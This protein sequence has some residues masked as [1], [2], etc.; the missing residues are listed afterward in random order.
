MHFLLL[1]VR[2]PDD[3]MRRQEVECFARALDC[4]VEAISTVDLLVRPPTKRKL[5]Q[6]DFV[7]LGG[8]G[9]YSVAEGGDWLEPALDVMRVLHDTSKPTFASCWGFQAMAR[10]LGGK[11][12]TDLAR[13]ELGT[14]ELSLT[15][16][17]ADDP[18]CGILPPR[19]VAHAGHQDIV[20][21][22]PADAVRL[23]RSDRVE[24]Q[25]FTFRNRPL[26]CTQF[27]PE[28]TRS[29]FIERLEQYPE[30]IDR[31]LHLTLEEFSRRVG[32]TPE[33]NGLLKRFVDVVFG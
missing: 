9:D 29:T 6:A 31:I 16:E 28:L 23:A 33:A 12:V 11:V 5:D 1:Q 10:A 24:N 13:A 25:A 18:V 20:E 3:P 2:N 26:F 8:S 21:S 4:G 15:A 17:G 32:E 7:L 27:H 22:L 19:F 30:Y 14:I